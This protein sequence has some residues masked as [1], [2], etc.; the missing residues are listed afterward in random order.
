MSYEEPVFNY[1]LSP[2]SRFDASAF[3]TVTAKWRLLNKATETNVNRAERIVRRM[4][5]LH[6]IITDLEGTTQD[7]SV[8]QETSQIRGSRQA[9]TNV[10]GRSF[11]LSSKVVTDKRNAFKVYFYGPTA[12]I[13]LQNQMVYLR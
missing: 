3:V 2:A 6:K 1:R 12:A 5:L 11:S 13:L 7:H 10:S 8:L 9:K 4:C